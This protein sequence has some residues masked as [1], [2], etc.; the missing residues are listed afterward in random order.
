MDNCLHPGDTNCPMTT[1]DGGG[2]DCNCYNGDDGCPLTDDATTKSRLQRRNF[3]V[4]DTVPC[5]SDA[6][7]EDDLLQVLEDCAVD[8]SVTD[9]DSMMACVGENLSDDCHD[10]V[11]DA[12]AADYNL[13]CP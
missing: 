8:P 11:C 2:C 3:M 10:C 7:C 9:D 13:T 1:S 4:K 12:F 6:D 5:P